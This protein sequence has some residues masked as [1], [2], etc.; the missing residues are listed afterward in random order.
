MTAPKMPETKRP[1]YQKLLLY[2]RE[3]EQQGFEQFIIVLVEKDG[4]KWEVSDA[5]EV[6]PKVTYKGL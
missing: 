1:V 2:A 6:Q 4:T 5:A 3:L